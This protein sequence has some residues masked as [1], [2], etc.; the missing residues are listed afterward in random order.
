D[1]N[2]DFENFHYWVSIIVPVLFGF[3][4]IVGFVG[5]LMVIVSVIANR[6][7][8]H[9]TNLLII[10]LAIADLL[11]IVFCVPFTAVSYAIPWP[12]GRVW[13]Q[14]YQY[15][16]L[17]T[18]ITSVYTLVLMSLDRF[19]AVCYPIQSIHIRTQRNTLI[20]IWLLT[21][22]IMAS[23]LPV[24]E[25]FSVVNFS[26][27]MCLDTR[28]RLDLDYA[29]TFHL[30]FFILGYA[31]PLGLVCLLYG[32]MLRRLVHGGNAKSGRIRKSNNDS[33]KRVTRLVVVVVSVF[34]LCWLPVHVI[35]LVQSFS[36]Q[37]KNDE[38][39][40]L[41]IVS[42]KIAFQCLAY[43][44]S[45]VNPVLYAFLSEQFRKSFMRFFGNCC[46]QHEVIRP[47]Q[48]KKKQSEKQAERTV[49]QMG[50]GKKNDAMQMND[51][52]DLNNANNVSN[53]NNG[54]K[55]VMA[56]STETLLKDQEKL[57]EKNEKVEVVGA[58][59]SEPALEGAV[60]NNVVAVAV[61]DD[62]NNI[63]KEI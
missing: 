19:L 35:F 38:D 56:G 41:P 17:V 45:C 58:L 33:K 51:L 15:M 43:L 22:I 27:L 2:V 44:N 60:E 48:S 54:N 40:E 34:A 61:A 57:L 12:F 39:E 49:L 25:N 14:I 29:K 9:T 18:A 63:E 32:L 37:Q 36:R 28:M 42:I 26:S 46:P 30:C 20:A 5:N 47:Q 53:E 3:I 59:N 16:I 7:M 52:N 21:G 13:C 50:D 10:H 8:R 62:E 55:N 24:V 23:L 11:F 6:Q 31:I 1:D 4:S